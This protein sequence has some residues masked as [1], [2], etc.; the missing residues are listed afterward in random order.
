MTVRRVLIGALLATGAALIAV[1]G[2]FYFRDNFFTH[3]PVKTISA[4]VFRAG[5]IPWWNYYEGG[6]QPLAGNPN[7]LTF[8]PD[9]FLYL[10]LPQ[11]IAFNLHFL[12]HLAFAWFAMRA[13]CRQTGAS[14][15]ASTFA[16]TMYVMSGLAISATV[17]YNLITA[18]AL[19]P[20]AVWAVE[21]G[22]SALVMGAAFGLIG[23]A[24]EPVVVLSTGVCVLI[25]GWRRIR[26]IAIA[27]VVAMAIVS[28]QIFAYLDIAKEVERTRGFSALT[29]LNTSLSLRRVAEIVAGPLMGFLTEPTPDQFRGR[30]FSTIFLGIIVLPA[31][32]HGRR[33]RY[34]VIAGLMLFLA[35][36]RYN[37]IVRVAIES[38]SSL[39]IARYPE[40]FAIALTV[41]LVVIVAAF[42]D[43]VTPRARMIWAAVTFIP[44]AIVMVLA[45]PIDW[46]AP[47][48]VAALPPIARICGTQPLDW[49]SHRARD[50][51]R[52]AAAHTLPPVFGAVAGLR[53]GTDRSPE[54]MHSLMSRVVAER[55]ASTK[56]DVSARYKRICG[57]AVDG[58]LPM[59]WI[60]PRVIGVHSVNEEVQMIESGRFDE[61]SAA[62]APAQFGNLTS[63]PGARVVSYREGLQEIVV[64]VATPSPA[65]LLVNQ[66]YFG[67]WVATSGERELPTLPLDIDRLGVIVPAGQQTILLRFGKHRGAAVAGWILSSLLLLAAA[68]ALR[69]EKLDRRAGEVERAADENRSLA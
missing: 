23:L 49:G 41:A 54:G 20:F 4:R 17:F 57:C 39:R 30:L 65:L 51:Y 1:F 2:F 43:R 59:A 31:L 42:L 21:W 7:T 18:I 15:Y 11:H 28:P 38:F 46:F 50:E 27:G 55:V 22:E 66:S 8:Y 32:V 64:S 53:Y 35:L 44:L 33:V 56:P 9:N 61:H 60:A 16:A 29:T 34:L 24:G 12:I 3:Y 10:I 67:A 26:Q 25:I 47:Y 68:I 6:G 14:D 48:R 52:Y 36:G 58:A 62:L 19:V 13:L 40:K 5:Q 37:P 63:P 69:I 45:A